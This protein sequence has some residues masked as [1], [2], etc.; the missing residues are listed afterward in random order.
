VKIL[1]SNILIYAANALAQQHAACRQWLEQAL[2]GEEEI[3]FNWVAINGFLRVVTH[4]RVLQEPLPV[5]EALQCVQNWLDAPPSR[6]VEPSSHHWRLLKDLLAAVGTGGNLT[7]DAHL[8]ALAISH[9]A[10]LVST[11]TDFARFR[12][13]KW[14]NPL[15]VP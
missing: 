5:L 13:L 14:E 9:D 3:G 15:A 12:R 11:D 8:A 1:D 2:S 6:I 7:T 4:P 10:T